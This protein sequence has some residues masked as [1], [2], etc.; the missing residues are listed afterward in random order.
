MYAIRN[1]L[2]GEEPNVSRFVGVVFDEFTAPHYSK[3]GRDS[4]QDYI[5]GRAIANRAARDH[6]ILVAESPHQEMMGTME[7]RNL[8]HVSLLFVSGEHQNKG[9]GKKL[10]DEAISRARER[11]MRKLSVNATPNSA[12]AYARL[13]FGQTDEEI[14]LNGIRFTRMEKNI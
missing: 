12:D 14:E 4:F 3:E 6:Y 7:V 2:A 5:S 11:G 1:M 13:G 10:L 8:N 9:V